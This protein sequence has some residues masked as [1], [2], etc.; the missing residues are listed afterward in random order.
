MREVG[1]DAGGV[2][3]H[4]QTDRAGRGDHGRLGVAVAML[5]AELDGAVPGG[6]GVLAKL[7]LGQVGID[8]RHRIDRELLV[9]VAVAIG[10]AAMVAHDAQHVDGVAV[11]VREG[12]ELAGHFGRGRIGDAG[13][14]RS[15]RGAD[16]AALSRIIGNAGGH[17]QA[18]DIGVAETERAV[19]VGKLGDLL[20]REL[21]HHHRDF[22]HDGPQPHGVLVGRDVDRAVTI[23]VGQEVDGGEVAGRVVEEHV[24]RARVRRTDGAG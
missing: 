12:A 18:A 5:L 11:V 15:Q 6:A 24:F 2:A 22:E 3:I 4:D 1:L 21:R 17:Q 19:F 13:H 14:D 8:Q 9:A 10:G 20:R 23:A 7:R 16:G